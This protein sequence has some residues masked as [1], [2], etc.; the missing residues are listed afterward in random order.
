MHNQFNHRVDPD[1][2]AEYMMRGKQREQIEQLTQR[3][4]ASP[5]MCL[6]PLGA[7]YVYFRVAGV[8]KKL[9]VRALVYYRLRGK[10][11]VFHQ[12][13]C[14]HKNCVNPEHQRVQE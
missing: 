1:L 12:A 3:A 6:L 10:A 11:P 2:L 9:P 13:A 7:S 14:G 8:L 5:K 4:E